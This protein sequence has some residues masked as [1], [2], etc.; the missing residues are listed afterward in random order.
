MPFLTLSVLV[1]LVASIS[2]KMESPSPVAEDLEFLAH[3]VCHPLS[4]SYIAR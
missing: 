3:R 1:T 2:M 4:S